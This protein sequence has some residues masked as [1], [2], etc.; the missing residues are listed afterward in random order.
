MARS[1][2]AMRS[3]TSAKS[4]RKS[5]ARSVPSAAIAAARTTGEWG[6]MSPVKSKVAS[7][8]GGKV[9]VV[10]VVVVVVEVVVEEVV[11]DVVEDVVAVVVVLGEVVAAGSTTGVDPQDT[12]STIKVI[13]ILSRFFPCMVLNL[14]FSHDRTSHASSWPTR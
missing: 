8:G 5:W 10:V 6:I 7:R 9:V 4:G 1:A 3:V 13:Q 12:A 2:A 14:G 11:E